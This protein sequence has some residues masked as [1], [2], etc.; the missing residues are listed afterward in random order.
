[1]RSAPD[2][3]ILLTF[4]TDLHGISC[5]ELS[6]TSLIRGR[7]AEEAAGVREFMFSGMG[8]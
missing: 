6:E 5:D 3:P 2:Y 1:M 8:W 7:R 4:G